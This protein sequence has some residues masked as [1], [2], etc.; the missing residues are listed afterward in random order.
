VADVFISY[1][2]CDAEFVHH[3]RDE[4]QSRGKDVWVDVEGIRD[5]EVFPEALLRAVES[6]DAFVFV[7]SPDA[8]RSRFCE[9][10]VDH[11]LELH[12]RVVPVS[13]RAVPDSEVPEGIRVRNWIPIGDG[14][15][16]R[17]VARLVTAI[18]TDLEWER[19]HSRLTVK[20]LEWEESGRDRSFLLRGSE[21]AAAERWL[22]AAAEHESGANAIEQEY[23]LAARGARSRRQRRLVGVSVAVTAVAVGLLVFALISRS[24]A[25]TAARVALADSLGAQAIADPHLDR[26]MLLGAE[27]VRLDPSVRTQGDLLTALLRAPSALR[28]LHGDGLRVNGIALSPNG[29]IVALEDNAPN[30]LLLNAATG[31][32]VGEVPNSTLRSPP[33]A[34][35]YL[36]NGRLAFQGGGNPPREVDLIDPGRRRI[37]QRL[38][39]PQTVRAA[40][41]PSGQFGGSPNFGGNNFAL[42][43]RRLLGVAVAGYA[44]QWAL[45]QGRLAAKPFRLP[46]GA[47]FLFYRSQGHQLVSVGAGET[48]VL[49]ARSGKV[50]R[51]Y[52]A[53]GS[54]AALSPDGQTLVLGDV[55]GTVRFLNLESGTVTTSVAAHAGAVLEVGVTPDGR[56]A[57]TSGDDGKSL[58]WDLATH[59][60]RTSLVGHAGSIRGQAISPDGS[61]LYT[62]SFDTTILAWDLSGKRGFVRSFAGARSNPQLMAW[63][64]AVSPNGRELAVGGSDGKVNLWDT[65]SLQRLGSFQAVPGFVG[66]LS[67]GSDG[68]TLLVAGDQVG[69]HPRGWLR[70]WRL[71]AKPTIAHELTGGPPL[72]T[73]AAFSPD[74]RFV[75]ATGS[76][77]AQLSPNGASK[78]DGLVAEW[79]AAGRLVSP[80]VRLAGGGL[81][82]DVSFARRGPDVAVTQLG[83]RV[84][85]VDP[86]RGAVVS[87]WQ[88]SRSLQ[89]NG[90]AL[91]PG[92]QRVAT[93]DFDGFLREWRAADGTSTLPP[94]R[95]SESSA[96]SVNWSPDGSRL[97]TAGSDS[98]VRIYDAKTGQQIGT[99][100]P[101]PGEQQV[102][103]PYAIYSQDG[104]TIAATDATGRVWLYPAALGGWEA[105]ACR[106]ADRNLTRGEW[107]KYVPGQPYRRICPGT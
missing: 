5:A 28:T 92:G 80:P 78:G 41:Q 74:G 8:V 79:S 81:A 6:S 48:A 10:E 51:A 29:R 31:A 69:P 44:V 84:A 91:S 67:F 47:G 55:Q 19:Q 75:A 27:A 50:L 53:G 90:A 49:D 99:S 18:E 56:S 63:N 9:Q 16:E 12:K 34:I 104:R 35:A 89:A 102:T 42:G 23:L 2:R 66:A 101:M 77:A 32:R 26:A 97:V 86:P 65:R 71:G 73:W 1:S 36:A 87:R 85:V 11:A 88:A 38:M 57:V 30:I 17:G 60:V 15:F 83:N 13:L 4:L 3:L 98:T 82:I 46:G 14:E 70:I 39:L 59:Q 96:W 93:V 64:V 25:I 37:A 43:P 21:L 45:P 68:R 20:A 62:G 95:A 100:L 103:D 72:Y 94:I 76:T 24:H 52:K 40:I 58:V 33:S 106:L 54:A 22:T 7:I 105:Y 61:T 107:A